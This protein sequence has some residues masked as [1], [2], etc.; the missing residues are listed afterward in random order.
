MSFPTP[1]TKS[2]DYLKV[3]EPAEDSFLFL[4][5]LEKDVSNIHFRFKSNYPAIV[6]EIGTGSGIVTTFVQQNILT[7]SQGLYLT[8]DLNIHAC[9]ASLETSKENGGCTYMDTLRASLATPL[10]P[11]II[12]LLL[13]NPPY[14]PDEIVP[15]IPQ[16]DD[17]DAWLDLA[18]LGGS[19]GM[20][21]TWKLLNELDSILSSRGAA[22]II[23]CKRNKPESVAEIM[24]SR[25]W[26]ATQIGERKAGWEVLSLWRFNR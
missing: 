11:N 18:L 4:D 14:V 24:Q 12:D 7:G 19:D 6:L 22:Y 2:V 20:E 25:G 17:D 15:T 8:T 1:T 26:T 10:R 3:Y 5:M 9:I 23:F 16:T 21:V 13:F